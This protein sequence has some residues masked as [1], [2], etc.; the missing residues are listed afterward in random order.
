M[1][2]N[3]M[4]LVSLVS[5]LIALLSGCA[6]P[7]ANAQGE[8]GGDM[9]ILENDTGHA[10]AHQEQQVVTLKPAPTPTATPIPTPEPTPV[11]TPTPTPEIETPTPAPETQWEGPVNQAELWQGEENAKYCYLT[12]DDGPSRNTE[13]ILQVLTEKDAVAT[14]FVIGTNAASHPERIVAIAQQGS[15]V[16]NHTQTHKTDEIYQSEEALMEDLNAGRETI[17]SILGEEY[18]DDLMRFPY[19]S[20][21]RRCRDYREAVEAAG[22]RYFDWNALNGDAEHGAASRSA[23]DLYEQLVETVDVQAERGRDLIILMHD[24]NSKGKTVEMLDEAIDYIRG[25][26]YTFATLENVPME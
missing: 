8:P 16:A 6:A 24:T 18:T 4:I 25:L 3:A 14:F 13:A 17:L 19:G 2:K 7:L 11:W 12:F 9:I 5:V 23:S 20:T 22:Y 26:G 21:N 1:R 15:L 10:A